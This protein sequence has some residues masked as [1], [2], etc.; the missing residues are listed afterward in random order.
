MGAEPKNPAKKR[1]QYTEAA[2][3]LLAVPMARS[4][5]Q[6]TGGRMLTLRPQISETGAQTIGPKM[7]PTLGNRLVYIRKE[8]SEL[9][10]DI[11]RHLTPPPRYSRQRTRR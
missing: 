4:A 10:T 8:D 2:F 3:V 9:L 5:W 1:V 6:K 7:K 11:M